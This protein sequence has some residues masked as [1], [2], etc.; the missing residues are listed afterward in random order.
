MVICADEFGT[1]FYVTLTLI[2]VGNKVRVLQYTRSSSHQSAT[3]GLEKIYNVM[4]HKSYVKWHFDT[5]GPHLYLAESARDSH[6][7]TGRQA[8]TPIY[9]S[10]LQFGILDEVN[11]QHNS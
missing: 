6:K 5:V 3:K 10:E 4:N 7:L 9:S 2:R 8:K 11:T 1:E